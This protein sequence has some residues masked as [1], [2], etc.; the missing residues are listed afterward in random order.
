MKRDSWQELHLKQEPLLVIISGLSGVGKDSIIS[1]L[2]KRE[3][4]LEQI[5]TLTTRPRRAREKDNID[6]RFVTREEFK[7][8]V[9][10]NEL[11]EWAEVYGNFYGVPKK[12]VKKALEEGKDVLLKVDI[13]GAETLKR[14]FPQAIL[15]FLTTASR[16]ELKSRLKKRG[17]E[18]EEELE[19]RLKTAEEELKKLPLFDYVILNQE[20]EITRAV[21]TIRAI[22]TA[23][24]HRTKHQKISL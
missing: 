8:M 15:I 13:Q 21:Q 14:I 11:L 12:Q 6:Y 18:S 7:Q 2:K 23:E 19:L 10:S 16:E 17:T 1:R 20:G 5:T 4:N 24:K 22:I 3:P 9:E